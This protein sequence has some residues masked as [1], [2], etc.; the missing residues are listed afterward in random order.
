[1]PFFIACFEPFPYNLTSLGLY[2]LGKNMTDPEIAKAER[3]AVRYLGP[4]ARSE[5]EMREYLL[6]KFSADAVDAA[7]AFLYRIDCLDDAKFAREWVSYKKQCGKG[8]RKVAFELERKGVATALIDAAIS[9]V[10]AEPDRKVMRVLVAKKS[11]SIKPEVTAFV[12][13][14][15]ISAFL[16]S[17]GFTYEEIANALNDTE[18]P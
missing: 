18:S 4:R 16:A 12:R 7:V 10:Y 17:R 15:K 8:R 6:R 14:Q 13:R 5:Y 2:Y 9:E 1:M 11:R 3:A